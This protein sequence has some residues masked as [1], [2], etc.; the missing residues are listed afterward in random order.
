MKIGEL[1]AI[2]QVFNKN[3][4]SALLCNP[5]CLSMSFI[6]E[7]SFYNNAFGIYFILLDS[8]KLLA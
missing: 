5:V 2:K 3:P 7:F 8:E 4:R 6:L 1:F